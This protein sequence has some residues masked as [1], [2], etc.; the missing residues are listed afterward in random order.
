MNNIDNPSPEDIVEAVT[1]SITSLDFLKNP[2][3][4]PLENTEPVKKENVI[5]TDS[6]KARILEMLMENPEKPPKIKDII[7]DPGVFNKE[8]DARE[9]EGLA[10]RRFIAEK[11]LKF[12]KAREWI[13]TKTIELN[14]E[15]KLFIANNVGT[16]KA[17]EMSRT[18][19]ND[20]E[21]TN[22]DL[23]TRSIYEFIKTIPSNVSNKT[24]KDEN[25]VTDNYKPPK[26]EDQTITRINRYV[27]NANLTREKLTE[28]QK[29]DI[30]NLIGYLH[31][32]RFLQEM[33]TYSRQEDR[34]L[35]ESE[36]IRCT[37]NRDLEE[38]EVSQYIM[39]CTDV[40]IAKDIK[41]RIE[42][43]EGAQDDWISENQKPNMTYVEATNGLRNEY[44]QCIGRQKSLLKALEGERQ[45]RMENQKEDNTSILDLLS[46]WKDYERRQHLLKLANTRDEELKE[47]IERLKSLDEIKLEIFGINP[48]ELMGE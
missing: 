9:M 39:Y 34:E 24:I 35:F 46:Y 30:K 36:F 13:P 43:F 7:K 47:E 42:D 19:F 41:K 26:T 22:L 1:K 29:R 23:E 44:N 17:L 3:V 40:V 25:L 21:L 18:L 2:P 33:G 4:I 15:Q 5:L 38:Q 20:T 31:T 11:G 8:I 14:E 48:R 10:V 6:Q 16:M 12:H 28:K 45:K 37:Y 32:T 27:N